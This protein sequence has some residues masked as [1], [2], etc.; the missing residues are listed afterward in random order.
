V[1]QAR[2]DVGRGASEILARGFVRHLHFAF[3]GEDQGAGHRAHRHR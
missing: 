2:D 3:R 1:V